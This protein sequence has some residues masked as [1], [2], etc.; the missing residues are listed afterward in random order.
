MKIPQGDSLCISTPRQSE[1][2]RNL[3]T[4]VP[5]LPPIR[6]TFHMCFVVRGTREGVRTKREEEREGRRKQGKEGCRSDPI[7]CT[8]VLVLHIT[9]RSSQLPF[10]Y[11]NV[12]LAFSEGA[13]GSQRKAPNWYSSIVLEYISYRMTTHISSTTEIG[14]LNFVSVKHVRRKSILLLFVPALSL[15]VDHVTLP[16]CLL[17]PPTVSIAP[18]SLHRAKE[19]LARL[20]YFFDW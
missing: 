14:E 4:P 18:N 6:P 20:V 13:H 8:R 19:A 15:N 3:L 16:S 10:Q 9:G 12:I 1:N 11:Y 5:S 17:S 7:T 2:H